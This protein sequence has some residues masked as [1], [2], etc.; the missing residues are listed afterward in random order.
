MTTP[1]DTSLLRMDGWP[2]GVNNRIR[3]TEQSVERESRTI[4][5]SKFLRKALNVD[6]TQEG[7]PIRRKG[8]TLHTAGYAHS[9]YGCEQ[10]GTFCTVIDGEL[11]AGPD[12]DNLYSVAEVNRYN[13]MS[14][15]F[16]ND[17][18][19]YSNG[20][21][22]GEIDANYTARPW[23]VPVGPTP[24]IA[25]PASENPDGWT[26]TRQVAVTYVDYYGR[27]GG[28]SEPVLCGAMGGPFTVSIPLPLPTDVAEAR[29]YVS[30]P[31][32]EI[33]Y[34]TQAII[35]APTIT[36]Y[37][38]QI[39]KGKELETLNMQPPVAGQLVASYK[40]RMYIARNDKIIF[41]EALQY[42]LT[43]PSQGIFMFPSYITL[44]QPSTDGIYVGTEHGIVF[45]AGD[46]PYATKQIHV[47]STAPV[48]NAVTRTSETFGVELS[49]DEIPIW[50][51]K[52][53]V[54]CAGFPGGQI[55]DL[56]GDRL[57]VSAH[58]AGAIG[59]RDYE[60]MTHIVSSLRSADGM[61]PVGASDT[62]VAT[63]RTNNI[64]L[65]S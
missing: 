25:G 54:L 63:V 62:V 9:V 16:L 41:T 13:R 10:L 52:G 29:V 19:Y 56:T 64:V 21:Q 61:N 5:S 39:G 47:S 31:N 50:W 36:I 1:S 58:Q 7:H 51:D 65:N 20:I 23:G 15:C 24:T 26:E 43:R 44:L 35:A 32:S 42:H 14:Y 18:I 34:Y 49:V 3:E 22:L 27:E 30:Q 28:A 48:E 38:D 12:P 55:K 17:T 40:G 46:D 60:G 37:P 59:V 11:L 8:Y 2:G 4:P 57:E 53:G 33:L 45:L 6:L